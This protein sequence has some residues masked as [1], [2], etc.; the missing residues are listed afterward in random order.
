MENHITSIP[1]KSKP[2]K[3]Y[4]IEDFVNTESIVSPSISF[5]DESILYSSDKTGVYN[6]YI[7]SVKDGLARQITRSTDDPI[8]GISFFPGDYRI[9]YTSNRGGNELN[10]I[11]VYDEAGNSR[12][13]TPGENE[14]AVFYGW[15][16]D[17]KSFFYGSNKRDS[18]FMDIYEMD[19]ETFTSSLLY[20]NKEGYQFCCISKDKRFM[21][22]IKTLTTN[23]S[24]M[25]VFDQISG[26]MKWISPHLGEVNHF[27]QTFDS[28][29]GSL[30]FLTDEDHEFLY[31]KKIDFQTG[32][33]EI[34]FKENWDIM[35]ASLSHSNKYMVLGINEDAKTRVSVIDTENDEPL[36][37]S[38]LPNGQIN[39]INISRSEKRFCFMLNDSTSPNNLY[40]YDME[41]KTINK[42][43]DT[44]NPAIDSSDLAE[45]VVVRY[46]SFDGLDIPAIYYRPQNIRDDEKIPALVW[47]H[48]GPGG[49]SRLGYDPLIQYIVNHGYAVIA[50]NNR[51]SS[52]YG[53]T[54]F[55]KA[56]LKHGDV[57]LADCVEAK[58][59]L[60]ST[61][62]ID[63]KKIGILGGSYGG[64]MVLAALAF[65]P[66]EFTV[67]VNIFGISNWIR[68]LKN[69]PSWWEAFRD[70]LYRKIG[71][72]YTDEAYVRSI[73]PLFHAG[74]IVKPL[75]VLQGA[76]DPRVLKVESDEIV[77]AVGKNGT[78][79]EYI[80]FD[81]EGHGFSKKENRLKGDR[82][83]LVFLDKYL[84][85]ETV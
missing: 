61:G 62:Y 45:G 80:V 60:I 79:V 59:F 7:M 75:L 51:G 41:T 64:Y 40:V 49:Q 42:L 25:Y 57:D 12:D 36:S 30:Y 81:D 9:L 48:G 84:K 6:A 50:V 46:P 55:K 73:S 22:F 24:N 71:N 72:P 67:G 2:I 74:N 58:K 77:E 33:T 20:E 31:L 23:D 65:K 66:D 5:D 32:S 11:Y 34:V 8:Y 68:T 70:A 18:K 85:Q 69:I 3:R 26:E 53:K 78:P 82:S 13:L 44:L 17:E 10:H 19:I 43:T 47:V 1:S 15:S 35:Y 29:S 28:D 63:E 52:G 38:Q 14:K 76:N 54:F 37:L 16:D 56:D 27:P 83:I 4:S 21:A 39:G